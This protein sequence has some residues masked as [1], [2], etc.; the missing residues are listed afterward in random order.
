MFDLITGNT[1]H[2]PRGGGK[3][4][5]V[6]SAFH[7]GAVG[8]LIVL[9]LLYVTNALPEV[10]TMM[11]FVAA[12]PAPPPPPPPPPPP[13]KAEPKAV[14]VNP[15]AAPVEAPASIEPEKAVA[16]AGDEGVAGGVE[17][18]PGGLIGGI[19]GGIPDVP[20]PPP[21]PP[22]PKAPVRVGGQIQQP[23]LLTKVNP[24][25]P[26]LAV[27]AHVEGT[28]ILEAIVNENGD[29]Q[30]V[31]VLRSIPLLDKS[32]ISAVEQWR[33]SPVILNGIRVPFILTVVVSFKIPEGSGADAS[34][35]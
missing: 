16:T 12:A 35:Y 24:T 8:T 33:Y 25:Y 27:K 34:R 9:P 6:S 30:S 23:S 13:V 7:I 14:P 22:A 32:A 10:P 21:P 29:V 3:F 31:R 18:F 20:P 19:V 17:G 15:N 4:V 1:R 26:D 11:A 2:M 28:V 5:L